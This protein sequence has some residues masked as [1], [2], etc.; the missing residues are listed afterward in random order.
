M[1]KK[2]KENKEN[3]EL[4]PRISLKDEKIKETED[5]LQITYVKIADIEKAIKEKPSKDRRPVD[6]ENV[7]IIAES[8]EDSKLFT[9]III[10]EDR[11]LVTGLHRLFAM[12]LLGREEIPCII[13]KDDETAEI[14][15]I[16]ENLIRGGL[17]YLDRSKQLKRRQEIVYGTLESD[18]LQGNRYTESLESEGFSFTRNIAQKIKVSQR[19]IQQEIQIGK[20]LEEYP[21]LE[22][23]FRKYDTGKREALDLAMVPNKDIQEEIVEK[24]IAGEITSIYEILDNFKEDG[25][26]YKRQKIKIRKDLY[27][28]LMAISRANKME[29]WE[30][31]EKCIINQFEFIEK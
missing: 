16:D 14:I 30:V 6:E 28:K 11:S 18:M 25:I 2:D 22:E 19:T 27:D 10:K 9:P 1:A 29:L 3:N 24:L 15:N 23:A 5:K 17:H 4:V 12:K 7:K 31:I 13:V 26:D 20:M 8:I 21:G